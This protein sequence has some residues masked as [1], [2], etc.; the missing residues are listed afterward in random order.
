MKHRV[1]LHSCLAVLSLWAGSTIHAASLT[2][3]ANTGV[4]NAQDGSGVW[5]SV[6]TNWWSGTA[7]AAWN[8]AT[9]DTATFGNGGT[10][11]VVTNTE[12]ISVGNITFN[13]T[14][15]NTYTITGGTNAITLV[16]SPTLTVNA[17]NG[18]I[19]SIVAGS[20]FT[21]AGNG[22]LTL[23][24]TNNTFTGSVT[25]AGGVVQV[26]A[27]AG[28]QYPNGLGVNVA[29]RSVTVNAGARLQ[30]I[31]RDI[32]GT[33]VP[34]NVTGG[35]ITNDGFSR[36]GPLTL[37]GGTIYCGVG[38]NS[39]NFQNYTIN[40]N[41]TVAG[42]S[43]SAIVR[44]TTPFPSI[45]LDNPLGVTFTVPDV[46]G[47]ANAD[48][49]ISANLTDR[50]NNSGPG[51]LLKMGGGT[52]AIENNT[53]TGTALAAEG[54]LVITNGSW[55]GP[56]VV[57]NGATVV[58]V[59]GTGLMGQYYRIGAPNPHNAA[60]TY[61]NLNAYFAGLNV[62]QLYG[63]AAAG[64]N[65]DFGG[66]GASF[67]PGYN[68]NGLNFQV[69]WA[70]K[71][72]V[73]TGG[74]YYMDTASDDGSM[75]FIDGQ[76]IANN[77][78]FQGV[79]A[80]GSVTYLSAGQHDIL[81]S[82]YQGGGGYGMYANMVALG[83]NTN[84]RLA[85]A[86]LA[87]GPGIGSL[88][89]EAGSLLSVS[90]GQ[91]VVAQSVAGTFAGNVA[92]NGGLYK[93]GTA[94][95]TLA[96]TN[97][98]SGDTTIAGGTLAL[99]DAGGISN[100][101]NISLLGGATLDLTALP[102]YTIRS[103]Q[104][105]G[106][107]GVV[108]G[109]LAVADGATLL[110]GGAAVGA[111]LHVAGDLALSADTTTRF[112]LTSAMAVGESN[113]LVNVASNLTLDGAA[114][115]YLRGAGTL[116]N[117]PYRLINYTGTL[118][119]AFVS[120]VAA[121]ARASLGVDYGTA[122]QVNLY[123]TNLPAASLRWNGTGSALWDNGA[124]SNW[125][126]LG[127][128]ANDAFYPGDSVSIEDMPGVQTNIA[129]AE[130][131][132][133]TS[134]TV[135]NS[136]N[137]FM[138]AGARIAGVTGIT[139]LGTNM[140]SLG[141]NNEF[142]G[143][144]IVS[145]G[146]LRALSP[147]AFGSNASVTV[148]AG[149]QVQLNGFGQGGSGIYNLAGA[150]PDGRGA[151]FNTNVS[152]AAACGIRYLT[153]SGDT[154]FGSYG[155]LT[156]ENARYDIALNGWIEGNG[157][158]MTKVGNNVVDFR[159]GATNTQ[160][161]VNEGF[162][163]GE[164]VTNPFG[165]NLV[166]QA[167]GYAG[168]YGNLNLPVPVTLNGG[169]LSARSGANLG[170]VTW[171]G[172]VNVP[173]NSFIASGPG[174]YG[175]GSEPI[176]IAG[177]ITGSGSITI[178][179][180]STVNYRGTNTYNGLTLV[181]NSGGT[182]NLATSN[183]L[184]INGPVQLGHLADGGGTAILQ[185]GADN[186]M[187]PGT[188]LAMGGSPSDWTYLKLMGTT[189]YIET[190][191]TD[192]NGGPHIENV[193]GE[194][195]VT[196]SGRLVLTGAGTSY[197]SGTYLRDKNSGSSPGQVS[198][199]LA[200]SGEATLAGGSQSTF[201][202]GIIVSNGTL[203]LKSRFSAGWGDITL[204]GGD[205]ALDG[206][207]LAEGSISS[208]GTAITNANPLNTA[209]KLSQPRINTVPDMGGNVTWA[210]TGY[211]VNT[212]TSAVV[213]T[214]AENFD[215]NI[216]LAVDD[217]V[218]L[219]NTSWN[220]PTLGN[221]SLSP[222]LH[223]F[224]LRG[225][226]G[227]GNGGPNAAQ[228]WT[229]TSFAFGYDPLGRGQTNQANYTVL[230][231]PGN[232]SMLC[233]AVV[234]TNTINL[235]A[236]ASIR[237]R[238]LIG[239]T[240]TI[241]GLVFDSGS[242]FGLTKVGEGALDLA[243]VGIYGGP[244]A[245]SNGTLIVN[246]TIVGAGPCT[247]SSNA[248]LCGTGSVGAVTVTIEANGY[249]GPRQHGPV[250]SLTVNNLVFS[251]NARFAPRLNGT[252]PSVIANGT[253]T[254]GTNVPVEITS[255]GAMSLGTYTLLQY[256]GTLSGSGSAAFS[257][258]TPLPNG[259]QGYLNDNTG[260]STIEL[261]ITNSGS[262]IRW[263]GSVDDKWYIGGTPNWTLL[264][265][266]SP[267]TF[268]Q[269]NDVLFDDLLTGSRTVRLT[270]AL[271][272][273]SITVSNSSGN[274]IISGG[275]S[276]AS[277]TGP[278]N[279]L[280]KGSGSLFLAVTNSTFTGSTVVEA[281][282]IIIGSYRPFGSGTTVTVA[283]GGQIHLNGFAQAGV[284]Q[285]WTVA[286]A[287]PDGSGAI[288]NTGAALYAN[289]SISNLT[290]TGDTVIAI[291][292]IGT[293]DAGRTDLCLGGALNAGGFQISK[294]G[295]S[296]LS[297]RGLTTGLTN[298][299]VTEGAVISENSNHS[300]GSNVVV[301]A[302]GKV[303]GYGGVV[304]AADIQLN[305]GTLSSWG[306]AASTWSGTITLNSSSTINNAVGV[307]GYGNSDIV[308]NGRITGPAGF[309]K[310]GAQTLTLNGASDFGGPLVLNGGT[311]LVSGA[312]TWS[313]S[314]TIVNGT[315]RLTG[316]N[317]RL[318]A[319][320]DMTVHGSDNAQSWLDLGTLNQSI[321]S[322]SGTNTYGATVGVGGGV[323]TI[324]GSG[325]GSYFG[326]ITGSGSI[327]RSGTGVTTLNN[328]NRYAG[329]TTINSGRLN[330]RH[331]ASLGSGA[332]VLNGG[333]LG[334]DA[335]GL[336]E[337]RVAGSF[338]L[339]NANPKWT[340]NLT[341]EKAN[342]T[343][344]TVYPDNTTY[345]YSGYLNV[346]GNTPVAWTFV[347][348]FDDSLLLTIDGVQ[349]INNGAW[350]QTPVAT[351]MLSPGLHSFELRLG[352]GTGGIGPTAGWP[353]GFGY[354]TQGRNAAVISN[355]VQ[356][357]DAGDGSLF[358]R[359]DLTLGNAILLNADAAVDAPVVG[360][361]VTIAGA[362]GGA[363]GFAKTGPG[364][365]VLIATNNYA[366]STVVSNGA[367]LI[368]GAN[369]GAGSIVVASDA[370]LWGSGSAAGAATIQSGGYIG[371]RTGVTN[372]GT[373]LTLP[374]L[375][376][377]TGAIVGGY[378]NGTNPTVR[379]TGAG[380]LSIGTSNLVQI[381][382][383]GVISNG[384][385]PLI[386][387]NTPLAGSGF[388]G[389]VL[390]P[391][392]NGASGY[393]ND[394]TGAGLVELV[395][396]NS[397]G[398]LRWY[399]S[400]GSGAWDVANTPHWASIPGAAA[401][402][403]QPYD[404]VRFDDSA[405]N[406]GVALAQIVTPASMVV[407]NETQDYTFSGFGVAGAAGLTKEGAAK[408]TLSNVSLFTGATVVNGGTVAIQ[409]DTSLGAP[410]AALTP[411]QLKLAAGTRLE[412]LQTTTIPLNR[413]IQLGTAGASGSVEVA[414]AT[415]ATVTVNSVI[416]D[417]PGATGTLVKSGSGMMTLNTTNSYRGGTV[418]NEGTLNVTFHNGNVGA[419]APGTPVQVNTGATLL[420]S[421]GDALGY[422]PN[423][424]SLLD[425]NG[426]TVTELGGA[427]FRITLINVSM[428]GGTITSPTNNS[429]DAGGNY[430]LNGPLTVN[431]SP[432]TSIID[433][434]AGMTMAQTSGVFNVANG[435]AAVD[436]FVPT[437][438]FNWTDALPHGLSKNGD[439]LML[440]TSASNAY[441]L[442]TLINAGTLQVGDGTTGTLGTNAVIDNGVLVLNVASQTFAQTISGTG[443]LVKTGSGY[444]RLTAANS[445][446]GGTLISNG[447]LEVNGTIGAGPVSILAGAT[448]KGT[449]T[450]DGA[451]TSSGVLE[452][453][454][455]AG[456]LNLNQGYSQTAAGTL[457]LEIA[458]PT[459][460]G[461]DFD[462]LVSGGTASLDGALTVSLLNGYIP[463]TNDQFMVLLAGSGVT[464]TFATTNLPTLPG[465]DVWVVT[466]SANTVVLSV[467]NTPSLTGYDLAAQA[468]PNPADRGYQSDAD[469]D[470]Y[471]NLLEYV[472]GGSLT[473]ADDVAKMSGARSNGVLTLRFTRNTNA[474]DATLIVEGSS[475]AANTATWLGIA[476]NIG[477][478]WGSTTN[479]VET[480][481]GTP[482]N[483][484]AF[485][486]EV[487]TNRFLRL[488][489]TRP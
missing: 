11:G 158:T 47:N 366:G 71:L 322:L 455:S 181:R 465:G 40:S 425:I 265:D 444:V 91:L 130:S 433:P 364:A 335:A 49:N 346:T 223:R 329:G 375:T 109:S 408:L 389:L 286:G 209:V 76:L 74:A 143:A 460:P 132:A 18:T 99:T 24:Y 196:A 367:L 110:P 117:G 82:F 102:G 243:G 16:N 363:A 133:P 153:L 160:L 51:G 210:Y 292:G 231:D 218:V 15:T 413:G 179:G 65:F 52:L 238:N 417:L 453:G 437:R 113:D 175:Y 298:L 309:A 446:S 59:G 340:A 332:V 318:P 2:W 150:G 435:A 19:S 488:R 253:T 471:A 416:G 232:G 172:P 114:H 55:S 225:F 308:I 445:Y 379:V 404:T 458:G 174:V 1:H 388:G 306:G 183:G 441:T 303:A 239:P 7:N 259:A 350:D 107:A 383:S 35:A 272:P 359:H 374:S 307:T 119:G 351:P 36:L 269:L 169:T 148:A 129:V 134:I 349:V 342:S 357:V 50:S 362:I 469:T 474:V 222:G 190:I 37:S 299:V 57:S 300:L 38:N 415:G 467:T 365:L 368:N 310:L 177:P 481:T 161:I 105:F 438:L 62:A 166:I 56:L 353:I 170:G 463:T 430:L 204:A 440:L 489:V 89:G 13:N 83:G 64:A 75:L 197:W 304:N 454:T 31:G 191:T 200:G 451:V 228:W 216:Y 352:E 159:G 428:T 185:M 412:G 262:G 26:G 470:G 30:L 208:T 334:L 278:A 14:G 258:V 268:N 33:L 142:T 330:V 235:Q 70:G 264:A 384:V 139:K 21:K 290:L 187:G 483:V 167:G 452:P 285:N 395:V 394:N 282:S 442:H 41:V 305:G 257:L 317:D 194:T 125:Y 112:D 284:L 485:D 439:G 173:S 73:A 377:D 226:N 87:S 320:T 96:G 171:S 325:S 122:N 401:A 69:R 236:D 120:A 207:G 436:L 180:A 266:G 98:F 234:V 429:G 78:F 137:A 227:G 462:F 54:V 294:L 163:Y 10:A 371:A 94:Q 217:N 296:Q 472:T 186:Q 229:N 80:R 192:D 475:S 20:G 32:L 456:Q 423:N 198:L 468:I 484:T 145:G 480:G 90:N 432:L 324:A 104:T 244:T 287:G 254:V 326:V 48:L 156:A 378:L 201:S 410:P 141:A 271:S 255:T 121:N 311:L 347:K 81:V 293:T 461:V 382:P 93:A 314:T 95:L 128:L 164:N 46:T 154:T 457:A 97:S 391:L 464:G 251:D 476:T 61:T 312:N 92:G 86:V 448:L 6:N 263:M 331:N 297:F 88:S 260:A 123:V 215:D 252:I 341:T 482:V 202:G 240:N 188:T 426:G 152:I 4:A 315:L 466:Y 486:Q 447:T 211:L 146:V 403:F 418:V 338:N 449:G 184:S 85:N 273:G 221:V 333:V 336:W 339:T 356:M 434:V 195:N 12:P 212:G 115:L 405:T 337:G 256:A 118:A 376:L 249:L 220:T 157:Y 443:S 168:A 381:V 270:Q 280:K 29:T 328:S 345:I 214:F 205:L 127:T 58:A 42:S 242:G 279:L 68:T 343:V 321:G 151:V 206:A 372:A 477:G 79:T 77:N 275:N 319:L 354:D 411:G 407:S 106:G 248:T 420:L 398:G 165:T 450:V 427:N 233:V 5:N 400:T 358:R 135:S 370:L 274:Y 230:T 53:A 126:N 373:T 327:V 397:G 402:V 17:T 380:S 301:Q 419:T 247:V 289:S 138:L 361:P 189:Q 313:N 360:M 385:Y 45:H 116:A 25:V 140:L 237:V 267:A 103:G 422:V 295:L 245:V 178:I 281:G 124:S 224:D 66:A 421:V 431:A 424:P 199:V 155:L 478:T 344:N 108:S 459:T 203:N 250:G 323:L 387:Y 406:F 386:A 60:N 369:N 193:E 277:L 288:V 111:T 100:S 399:G 348:R 390:G 479:I 147:N 136:A 393:L 213:Y 176:H 302:A 22:R 72:N 27:V 414:V 283:S 316:G 28:T 409:A 8:S 3:D 39:A 43:A 182:L 261:V 67:P 84:T 241:S 9:P 219:N 44:S 144:I 101:A 355:F 63:S 23:N 276:L 34:I 392:P 396:T 291:H 473:N 487:G 246:G 131:I 162:V 149:G